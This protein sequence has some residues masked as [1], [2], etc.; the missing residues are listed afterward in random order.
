MLRQNKVKILIGFCLMNYINQPDRDLW[1]TMFLGMAAKPHA[2]GIALTN[3]GY[4]T[5]T[6]CY[7]VKELCKSEE[8]KEFLLV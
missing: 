5:H 6:I 3:A 4:D 2:Q 7:E 8:F 1:D